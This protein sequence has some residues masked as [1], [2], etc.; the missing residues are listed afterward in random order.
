MTALRIDDLTVGYGK[1]APVVRAVCLAVEPGER[2]V[3]LGPSGAGKT[4]LL[5]AIAGFEPPQAGRIHINGV[6]VAQV[7]TERRGVGYVFQTYA[8]FPH[9]TVARNISFGLRNLPKPERAARVQAMLELV[10][11]EGFAD[12]LPGALSGG[13]QQRVALA[14]AIAPR[15]KILMLDEPFSNLDAALRDALRGRI[16]HQLRAENTSVLMV[17]HDQSEALQS[18]D[19]LAV[20]HAGQVLRVDTP[21]AIY[22]DPV[23]AFVAEF[24]GGTNRV[25][26]TGD[27]ATVQT[28]FGPLPIAA[29]G[30]TWISIRPHQLAVT[31]DPSGP[32]VVEERLFGGHEVLLQGKQEVPGEQ[33]W[34]A[35]VAPDH[36]AQVGDRVTLQA[37]AGAVLI[38]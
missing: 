16:L 1:D 31:V 34:R 22:A 32:A 17:T 7:P 24:L 2:V 26:G 20:M 4:T 36:P 29:S 15:P 27:G 23:T 12:R 14:R 13:Q 11:L 38:D 10:E 5:R 35:R 21:Q 18:A 30:T 19:R 33:P 25:P 28:P 6:D 37:L 9:L 3:L 8:L